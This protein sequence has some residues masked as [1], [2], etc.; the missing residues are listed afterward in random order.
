MRAAL[1]WAVEEAE[2]TLG[3]ELFVALE[4]YWATS[5]PEEGVDW[6][7]TLLGGAESAGD[8]DPGLVARALRVQGGMQNMLGQLDEN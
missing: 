8:V 1:T 6:A 7:V 4:N 5:L 2:W 3:L